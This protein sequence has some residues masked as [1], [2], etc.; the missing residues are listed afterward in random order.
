MA[1]SL[2]RQLSF[3]LMG[4]RKLVGPEG[5]LSSTGQTGKDF[6]NIQPFIAQI[7]SK[8]ATSGL[9]NEQMELRFTTLKEARC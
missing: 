4:L 7:A 3:N 9:A 2:C 6:A 8:L 1:N 5:K